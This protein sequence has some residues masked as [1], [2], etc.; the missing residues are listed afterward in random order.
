M[1]VTKNGGEAQNVYIVGTDSNSDVLLKSGP[2]GATASN[3][4]TSTSSGTDHQ[5]LDVIEQF[6][7]VAED[8]LNG[9]IAYVNKPLAVVTYTPNLFVN[10][11][12]NNTLNVKTGGGNVF[13]FSC[14]NTNAATRYLQLFNTTALPVNGNTP[15]LTF[16]VPA[17]GFTIVGQDFFTQ[18]GINFSVGIAFAFSTTANT[19][20][21]G[22]ASEHSFQIVY[23]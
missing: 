6:K 16:P 2:K 5:G 10:F 12:V 9:V 22:V 23:F 3:Y 13:S 21:L 11:G 17:L 7:P 19:L 4:V 15:R 20:T 14:Q 18:S 8:N 1:A